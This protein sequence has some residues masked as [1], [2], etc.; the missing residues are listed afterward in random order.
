MNFWII[1]FGV[2]GIDRFAPS[3]SIITEQPILDGCRFNTVV[4]E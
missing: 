1:S 3:F 4:D 2:D